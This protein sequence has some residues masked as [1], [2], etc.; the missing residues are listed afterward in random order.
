[1][2]QTHG[3]KWANIAKQL[4]GRSDN[5]VKNH[6]YSTIQ[7]KFQQH[8]KDVRHAIWF[9]SRSVRLPPNPHPNTHLP[10][11]SQKLI[12]A[13]IAQVAQ[14]QLSGTTP[15]QR[16]LPPPPLPTWHPPYPPV[17]G[18]HVGPYSQASGSQAPMYP[19]QPY[20]YPYHYP[21]HPQHPPPHPPPHHQG[22]PQSSSHPPPQQQGQ[23]MQQPPPPQ[24]QQHHP[25]MYP[26]PPPQ[27]AMHHPQYYHYPPHPQQHPQSNGSRDKEES[28]QEGR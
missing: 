19:T 7:R 17:A 21:Q 22:D 1:M 20:P 2:H 18:P 6:W 9:I 11:R 25:Y 27:H 24:Q 26:M 13:A 5:D 12:E 4:P 23:Q 8:G 10:L 15:A 28:H 14:M 16:E 3:N